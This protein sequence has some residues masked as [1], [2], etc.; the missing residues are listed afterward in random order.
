MFITDDDDHYDNI[1]E[2]IEVNDSLRRIVDKHSYLV[3]KCTRMTFRKSNSR[4]DMFGNLVNYK[5]LVSQ[6]CL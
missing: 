1:E 5:C 2:N 3:S 6:K 4:V